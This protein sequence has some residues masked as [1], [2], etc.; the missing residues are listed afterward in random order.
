VFELPL[1]LLLLPQRNILG[2]TGRDTQI[3][4]RKQREW[5]A[6]VSEGERERERKKR[7]REK[8]RECVC[9]HPQPLYLRIS[10]CD[11]AA[12]AATPVAAAT[13][14]RAIARM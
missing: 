1:Q 11:P 14:R 10:S 13:Q 9:T 7:E 8:N 5:D 6:R 12:L 2:E 4:P 3:R